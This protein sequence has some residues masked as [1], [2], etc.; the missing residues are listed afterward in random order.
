MSIFKLQAIRRVNCISDQEDNLISKCCDLFLFKTLG[1]F[2][3]FLSIERMAILNRLIFVLGMV[4]F[5]AWTLHAERVYLHSGE[6]LIGRIQYIDERVVALESDRGFGTIKIDRADVSMI[7]FE[8]SERNLSQKFGFGLYKR[9]TIANDVSFNS[10]SLRYWSNPL[11]SIDFQ[12]G[13]GHSTE[14][15]SKLQEY[16]SVEGRYSQVLLQEGRHNI[17]AGIGAG[18]VSTSGENLPSG[19]SGTQFSTFLGVELFPVSF[20]NLGIATEIGFLTQS[21]GS[22]RSYGLF[23]SLAVRYYF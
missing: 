22:R 16:F 4:I 5:G 19:T 10:A 15:N 17:Y 14:G 6:M 13:I 21:I 11:T 8:G 18:V 20:P 9:G 1:F 12:L 2:D 7:E 23:P 3:N